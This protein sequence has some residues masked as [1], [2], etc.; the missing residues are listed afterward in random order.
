MLG[1]GRG[2]AC[3]VEAL[4]S[5]MFYYVSSVRR[6]FRR[7]FLGLMVRR[8]WPS[9]PDDFLAL[10]IRLALGRLWLLASG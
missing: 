3:A 8:F 7:L 10:Y 9:E 2:D 1:E 5:F 4:C 6:D